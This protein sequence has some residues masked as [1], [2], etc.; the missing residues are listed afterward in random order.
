[1][2]FCSHISVD[3]APHLQLFISAKSTFLRLPTKSVA[4]TSEVELCLKQKK[5]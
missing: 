1:M 2:S 5:Y 4:V 3:I